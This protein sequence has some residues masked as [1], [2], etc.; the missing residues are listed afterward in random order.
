MT[1]QEISDILAR[2]LSIEISIIESDTPT[3][4]Q[5]NVNDLLP[6]CDVL[7]KNEALFFDC[8]SCLTGLD[9]GPDKN[10]EVIYNFYSIP[11]GHAIMLKVPISREDPQIES[12]AHIWK[13]ANWH[14]REA[15]DLLG[16]SF[17]NHPDLRRILLPTDWQGFPLRKDY[18]PQEEYHGVKVAWEEPRS[19]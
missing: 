18:Q 4:I 1:A 8:L 14:E 13:T 7:F 16:I 19:E 17:L 15:F 11:H 6:V 12:V 3:S 5:I 2:E 9:S 10:M